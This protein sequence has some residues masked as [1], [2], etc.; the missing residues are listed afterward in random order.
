V[1]ESF[2]R[3][4]IDI[5]IEFLGEMQFVQRDHG[6][7]DRQEESKGLYNEVDEHFLIYIFP[8][9][10]HEMKDETCDTAGEVS[11]DNNHDQYDDGYD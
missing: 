7:Q 6:H 2:E 8:N 3:N 5:Y 11:L 1:K 4:M 9:P 10:V